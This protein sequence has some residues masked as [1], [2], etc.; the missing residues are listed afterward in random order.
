MGECKMYIIGKNVCFWWRITHVL[1][2]LIVFKNKITITGSWRT[3]IFSKPLNHTIK[4]LNLTFRK[5]AVNINM[6]LLY[7]PHV[8]FKYLFFAPDHRLFKYL[9]ISYAMLASN[10][11]IINITFGY[12]VYCW[13]ILLKCALN[14]REKVTIV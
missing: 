3:P 6:C 2:L 11:S 7:Q 1:F 12:L 5:F 14:G 13:Q 8:I 4:Q 10:R 9:G